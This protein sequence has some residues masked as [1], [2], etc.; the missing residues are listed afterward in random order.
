MLHW[1]LRAGSKSSYDQVD[2]AKCPC[3]EIFGSDYWFFESS[4]AGNPNVSKLIQCPW[5]TCH[6]TE[7]SCFVCIVSL[8]LTPVWNWGPWTWMSFSVVNYL[9]S[10]WIC[11]SDLS[12]THLRPCRGL[13][14]FFFFYFR[15]LSDCT[16]T[17][18]NLLLRNQ[19]AVTIS[20][21]HFVFYLSFLVLFFCSGT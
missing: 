1:A 5:K 13:F 14:L 3:D 12:F 21:C 7:T 20:I 9:S 2:S 8:R 11:F 6:L 10:F 17:F 15:C 18:H 16:Y 19:R 4:P